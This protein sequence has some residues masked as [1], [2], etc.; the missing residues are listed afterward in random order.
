M[1][2]VLPARLGVNLPATCHMHP[3]EIPERHGCGEATLW[4]GASV[5]PCT[6]HSACGK[7][8]EGTRTPVHTVGR[9]MLAL[10]WLGDQHE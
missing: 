3:E 4:A 1:N 2:E 6:S 10:L 5:C 8:L 7:V 9:T